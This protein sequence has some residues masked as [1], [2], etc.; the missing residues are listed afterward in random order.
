MVAA[1]SARI[2]DAVA[3]LPLKAGMRVLEIGCGPGVA[4]REIV[5]LWP[6]VHVLGI[7]R[8]ASAIRLAVAGAREQIAAGQLAFR[9]ANAEEFAL[10]RGEP[11]FDLAFA[12][13][14]GAL[15]GRHPQA[16]AL[17]LPRIRAALVRG[18][19]LYV[20]GG[21]PLRQLALDRT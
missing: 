12:L 14:V 1:V 9:I 3:A 6:D 18:G 15:D 5:R 11:P 8:S 10:Q 2:R 4:A 17:A 20:D 19:P 21:N 7:D 13:R 16:G